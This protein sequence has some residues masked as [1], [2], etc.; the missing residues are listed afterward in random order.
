M[1]IVICVVI[2][3]GKKKILEVINIVNSIHSISSKDSPGIKMR[4]YQKLRKVCDT[5]ATL[6]GKH[7]VL[8]KNKE[9]LHNLENF[10]PAVISFYLQSSYGQAVQVRR[11]R[12]Q[13]IKQE[14]KTENSISLLIQLITNSVS[15]LD[16]LSERHVLL[17][18]SPSC[19]IKHSTYCPVEYSSVGESEYLSERSVSAA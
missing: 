17:M 14:N 7:S 8:G 9:I 3:N 13:A 15:Y 2:Y 5:L 18:V 11:A 6:P 10:M 1:T 16:F 19:R 4:F 12:M